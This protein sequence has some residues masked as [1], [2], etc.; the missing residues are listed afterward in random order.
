MDLFAN[1]HYTHPR[2]F[3][4]MLQHVFQVFWI[5]SL[6]LTFVTYVFGIDP[7]GVLAAM[8]AAALT[9]CAKI[10][11]SIAEKL[12]TFEAKKGT[13]RVKD[14]ETMLTAASFTN[15]FTPWERIPG[16]PPKAAA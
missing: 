8:S 1:E 2:A 10:R 7:T 14:R 12:Q 4:N 3:E 11:G 5:L 9:H 16:R 15:P 13:Q 6:C